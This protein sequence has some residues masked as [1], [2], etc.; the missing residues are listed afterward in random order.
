MFGALHFMMVVHV[1]AQFN[2]DLSEI[3]AVTPP[4]FLPVRECAV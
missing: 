3:P 2:L 1:A 4:S